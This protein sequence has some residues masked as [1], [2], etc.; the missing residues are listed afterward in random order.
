M[1]GGI[2]ARVCPNPEGQFCDYDDT[3]SCGISDGSGVCRDRP[4]ACTKECTTVCGCDGKIYCNACEA[5]R[6]G[7]DVQAVVKCPEGGLLR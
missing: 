4:T 5:N 1:C 2:A 6:A 3:A 7:T